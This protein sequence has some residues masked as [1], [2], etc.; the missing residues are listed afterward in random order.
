M[1]KLT[2]MSQGHR[3]N[4]LL[5]NPRHILSVFE[6]ELDDEKQTSIYTVTQQSWNVKESLDEI[7]NMINGCKA[8]CHDAS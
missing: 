2:N 3:H 8:K 1:I 7:Y 4:K 6:V 5:L